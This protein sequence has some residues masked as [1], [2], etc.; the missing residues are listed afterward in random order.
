MAECPKPFRTGF[1]RPRPHRRRRPLPSRPAGRVRFR[2]DDLA[3]VARH[4]LPHRDLDPHLERIPADRQR[5]VL[6]PPR[7]GVPGHGVR[8][9]RRGH[10][11]LHLAGGHHPRRPVAPRPAGLPASRTAGRKRSPA[12]RTA[13]ST[14]WPC[15]P[16]MKRRVESPAFRGGRATALFGGAELDLRERDPRRGQG[17]PRA[18]GHL[19]RRGPE[20]PDELA[21]RRRRRPHP[22]RRGRQARPVAEADVKATLYV[23]ATAI[24]GGIDIKN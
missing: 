13:T 24:F 21:A 6:L 12:S 20:G 11:E 18:H 22:G 9:P 17:H 23:K 7:R 4:L 19:R 3:L 1:R 16:D 15:S 5:S 14:S 2:D 8:P 10:L